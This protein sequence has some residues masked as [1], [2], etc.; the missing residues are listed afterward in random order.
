MEA[1]LDSAGRFGY[2]RRLYFKKIRVGISNE[3]ALVSRG[4]LTLA[5]NSQAPRMGL[6]TIFA[7]RVV[8]AIVWMFWGVRGVVMLSYGNTLHGKRV[9]DALG[10]VE[11]FVSILVGAVMILF[12][13]WLLAGWTS[14]AC[15]T[16]Q[17]A[18]II[19]LWW[20]TYRDGPSL[21]ET[22]FEQVPMV[23]LIIMVWT[24]GPGTCVWTKRRR[25]STWTRG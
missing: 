7:F 14:R 20:L 23:A 18:W 4:M 12:A 3:R 24:Y 13:F 17:L 22:I 1:T 16:L 8:L 11:P 19:F 15:A 2:R 21:L 6:H 10:I 9:A 25:R 5:K